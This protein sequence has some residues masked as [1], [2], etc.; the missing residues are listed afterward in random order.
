MYD[1]CGGCGKTFFIFLRRKA[2][3]I[4][5]ITSLEGFKIRTCRQEKCAE[6]RANITSSTACHR[7]FVNKTKKN[8]SKLMD[9]SNGVLFLQSH[10][11]H[12][13]Y[14]II[15]INVIILTPSNRRVVVFV[16]TRLIIIECRYHTD[17][18]FVFVVVVHL[19]VRVYL[20]VSEWA[21]V[22]HF[23]SSTSVR[24][25]KNEK[26]ICSNRGRK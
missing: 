2:H 26:Q 21:G 6:L 19:G 7:V 12:V 10:K 22:L 5:F 14:I 16:Y 17:D 18:A 23:R 1:G 25:T 24:W 9:V 4:V 13:Q 20:C 15:I 8:K 3:A 11:I